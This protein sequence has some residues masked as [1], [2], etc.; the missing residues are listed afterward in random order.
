M[1][2][3]PYGYLYN[4]SYANS[5][6]YN[7]QQQNPMTAQALPN[8]TNNNSNRFL[9]FIQDDRMVMDTPDGPKNVG[10]TWEAYQKLDGITSE[11]YEILK[12]NDLL[13]KEVN[14]DTVVNEELLSA[15]KAIKEELRESKEER[16][17]LKA[18]LENT[19]KLF[20]DLTGGKDNECA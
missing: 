12:T 1:Y 9:V 18:S 10:I 2:N 11:Y 5:N 3:N 20:N 15:L 7:Q 8:S 17:Q 16:E 4:S 13:P 6:N 14:P 19:N